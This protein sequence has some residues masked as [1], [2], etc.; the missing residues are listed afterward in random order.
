MRSS[1]AFS[2]PQTSPI[3]DVLAASV[4]RE[5]WPSLV[6]H[7][8]GDRSRPLNQFL[9]AEIPELRRR[10]ATVASRP[11]MASRA[12]VGSGISQPAVDAA[13]CTGTHSIAMQV[14]QIE[15]QS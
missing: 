2:D 14:F 13:T 1:K 10:P 11:Q 5:G 3:D 15:I 6:A 8:K 4:T 7:K 12:V 9:L